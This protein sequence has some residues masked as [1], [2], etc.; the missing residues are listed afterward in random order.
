VDLRSRTATRRPGAEL[1]RLRIGYHV[2]TETALSEFTMAASGTGLVLGHD[3]DQRMVSFRLFRPEPTR[4]AVVGGQWLS[5]VI[6]LRALALGA[7]VAIMSAQPEY[8]DGFGAWAT[9]RSDRVAVLPV[10]RPV[11]PPASAAEPG[12]LL[13]DAGLLGPSTPLALGPWQTQLTM[14]RQLTAYGTPSLQEAAVVIMQRLAEAEAEV[15]GSV[16][17]LDDATKRL[18]QVLGDDMVAM[19]GGQTNRYVWVTPTS[20]EQHYLGAARR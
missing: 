9:G 15:A 6:L 18:F 4:V 20:A 8:W 5:T 1:P 3:R 17:L 7:R 2:A 19:L 16:L 14:L 12:L 10:D 13:W 11:I